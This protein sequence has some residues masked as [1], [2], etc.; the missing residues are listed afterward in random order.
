MKVAFTARPI[1]Q[2]TSG[3]GMW[4]RRVI[5][6]FIRL[7]SDWQV[8][9]IKFND[10]P[11]EI[12]GVQGEIRVSRNPL[13]ASKLL[14]KSGMDIIH[15]SPITALSPVHVPNII[16]V[17]TIHGFSTMHRP[18]EAGF[19][20]WVQDRV[21]AKQYARKM[22]AI[23]TVSSTSAKVLKESYGCR[24]VVLAPPGVLDEFG[25]SAASKPAACLRSARPDH[26][27]YIFH[28]SR[29]SERKNPAMLLHCFAV[30]KKRPDFLNLRLKIAGVGWE[31]PKVRALCSSLSIQE[32]VDFLGFI[33]IDQQRTLL[34]NASAFVFPSHYEGFGMP[35][36]EAMALGC[37]V[38]TSSAFAIPEIVGD[39]AIVINYNDPDV[40]A[41]AVE[42]VIRD[43]LYRNKLISR[44]YERAK[45]FTW[46]A[47]A[48][49]L[50]ETFN[51][52]YRT[53]YGPQRQR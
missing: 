30:L 18:R 12:D 38:V 2:G 42:K 26:D 43:K 3:S 34:Q 39:A 23:F 21:F 10:S 14:R 22:D 11:I 4:L 40:Y 9:L 15:Y 16:R 20:R 53:R 17:A 13:S 35:N 29:Y 32:S 24:R 19:L 37:P 8:Y 27:A 5:T 52:L 28:I 1:E 47:S 33:S 31:C 46:E 44:G 48:R 7:R 36:I 41:N 51:S 6:S 25:S 50:L 45:H 49:S